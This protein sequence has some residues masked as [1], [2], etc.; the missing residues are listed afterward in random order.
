M[1]SLPLAVTSGA[2]VFKKLT[3]SGS[4]FKTT[5]STISRLET[6]FNL[7]FSSKNGRFGP[8]DTK[9]SG[10]IETS[11]TWR[12]FLLLQSKLHVRNE[13]YQTTD[14]DRLKA[15]CKFSL[16]SFAFSMEII[17]FKLKS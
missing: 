11:R 3:A 5:K 4:S 16:I 17:L 8:L 2:T 15:V 14:I 13:A 6:Y 9:R 12:I 10:V 1:Y 7:A